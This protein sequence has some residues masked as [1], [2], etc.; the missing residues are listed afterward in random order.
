MIGQPR[1]SAAC[2]AARKQ[3][4][5]AG[6]DLGGGEAGPHEPAVGAV[7]ALVERERPR[8]ALPATRLVPLPL[9]PP[10]VR[11]EPATRAE[12][13]AE[14]DAE[15]EVPR[16]LDDV[17][18]HLADLEHRGHAAPEQ[19]GHREVDAGAARRLVLG[20]VADRQRLEEARVVEL[21]PSRVLDERAV[22]RRARDVGVGRDE[23]GGQHAVARRPRSR[24]LAPRRRA[25]RRGC[26]RPP[27]RPRRSGGG[28]GRWP[29]KA[30][31]CPARIRMRRGVVMRGLPPRR[32]RAGAPRAG[33]SRRS[34]RNRERPGSGAGRRRWAG[35]AG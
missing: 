15:A 24:R 14:V 16:P 27:G 4:G 5:R 7:V 29:S 21:G 1:S 20:A 3:L 22:E 30:T 19:L 35:A 13:Q 33:E 34:C 17:I 2:L 28:G 8:E 32:A 11:R 31:T 9:D 6:V 26:D 12:R 25:R 23:T 10:A 18:A